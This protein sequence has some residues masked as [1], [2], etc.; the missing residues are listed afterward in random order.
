M[1]SKQVIK[2]L[3]ANGWT[4]KTISGSHY[5]MEKGAIKVPVPVHGAADITP[6]TVAAIQRQTGVKLK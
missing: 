1:N 6:G 3:K 5:Q 2:I 4:L